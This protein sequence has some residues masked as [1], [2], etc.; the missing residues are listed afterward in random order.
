MHATIAERPELQS[1]VKCIAAQPGRELWVEDHDFRA[2]IQKLKLVSGGEPLSITKLK[3]SLGWLIRNGYLTRR[4]WLPLYD[5]DDSLV[6]R[7]PIARGD[8]V[9]DYYSAQ[10]EHWQYVARPSF[11]TLLAQEAKKTPYFVS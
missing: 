8:G 10:G 6:R 4:R 11:D 9:T 1:V 3:R 2:T 5:L 7:I